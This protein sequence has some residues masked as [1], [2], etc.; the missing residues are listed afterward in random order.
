MSFPS[1]YPCPSVQIVRVIMPPWVDCYVAS[2]ACPRG[3]SSSLPLHF[4]SISGGWS[5]KGRGGE[6]SLLLLLLILAQGHRLPMSPHPH[7]LIV[8]L[9]FV[10]FFTVY[11]G[12]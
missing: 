2:V 7:G 4:P 8:V 6:G 3:P 9:I 5:I 1:P 10:Y 11:H 12:P